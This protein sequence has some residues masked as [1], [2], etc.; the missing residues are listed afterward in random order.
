VLVV[1]AA[2][3]ALAAVLADRSTSQR[4]DDFGIGIDGARHSSASAGDEIV[5]P[6]RVVVPSAGAGHK[7]SAEN[8]PTAA[9]G[10]TYGATPAPFRPTRLVLPDGQSASVSAVGL[11]SDG[12]LVIPGDPRVV[13][14]WTGGSMA[15]ETFG[16]VVVAGHV[17]SASRGIG[18]LAALPGLH[19]GQVVKL[20]GGRRSARY[21][22]VSARLV[23]QAQ[24]SEAG[25]LFRTDGDARLVLITC[26]GPF[27]PVRHRYA[28]NYVVVAQ[29]LP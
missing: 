16:N 20:T 2:A 14:W 24:L 11:H 21:R 9:V 17:D 15:G 27:D 22:I 29:P 23:P 4:A 8:A 26:G 6:A 12:S 13:G 5:R 19:T 1:A 7:A 28:D 18:V 3:S 25:G 10:P